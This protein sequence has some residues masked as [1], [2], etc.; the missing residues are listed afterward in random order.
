MQLFASQSE[1]CVH[2]EPRISTAHARVSH[3]SYRLRRRRTLLLHN[4]LVQVLHERLPNLWWRDGQV[5]LHCRCG[6]GKLSAV[7][8]R[9]NDWE[10]GGTEGGGGARRGGAGRRAQRRPGPK[11]G[12]STLSSLSA[13]WTDLASQSSSTRSGSGMLTTRSASSMSHTTCGGSRKAMASLGWNTHAQWLVGAATR[14]RLQALP[15]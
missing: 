13:L 1:G 9:S 3:K 4:G 10:V 8:R 11:P 7:G 6:R 14:P 12:F 5:E 15:V 2:G